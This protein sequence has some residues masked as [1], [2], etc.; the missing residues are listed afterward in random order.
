[1]IYF[2][3][4]SRTVGKIYMIRQRKLSVSVSERV[5]INFLESRKLFSL[6][7][8]YLLY[9]YIPYLFVLK[10]RVAVKKNSAI[11]LTGPFVTMIYSMITGDMFTFSIIYVIFLFGFSQAYFFLYKGHENPD[12]TPYGTYMS[13]WMGLLQMTLGDYDVS[14]TFP[15]FLSLLNPFSLSLSVY[16]TFQF[17]RYFT[18]SIPSSTTSPI[19]IW[20]KQFSSFS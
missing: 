14:V 10:L 16:L 13:T 8:F 19:R 5:N 7:I 3:C 18:H 1:M 15:P 20:R 12:E 11:R 17:S 6:N 4:F 9:F 2:G